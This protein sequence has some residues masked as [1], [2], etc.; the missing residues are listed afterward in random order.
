MTIQLD[1]A[2]DRDNI[3]KVRLTDNSTGSW[4]TSDLVD[5]S[6][7]ILTVGELVIDSSIVPTAFILDADDGTITFKIGAVP[8]LIPGIFD[9]SLV[10]YRISEPN[11][12]RW[13]P[14]FK[15]RILD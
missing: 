13:K 2:I 9:A 6:R 1:F 15:I 11:G 14:D 5:L 8:G 7:A 3:Q 4:I 10:I 12:L